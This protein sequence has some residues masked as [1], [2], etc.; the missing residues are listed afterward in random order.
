[1]EDPPLDAVYHFNVPPHPEAVKLTVPWPQREF[2]P[3]VAAPGTGFTV[4]VA[5]PVPVHPTWFVM[6]TLYVPGTV[7]D[8]P[9]K[10]PGLIAPEGTDHR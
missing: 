3:A 7:A 10:L 9:A 5:E 2:G 6:V 1:M 8:K 4:K